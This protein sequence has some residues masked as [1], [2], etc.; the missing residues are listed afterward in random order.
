MNSPPFYRVIDPQNYTSYLPALAAKLPA[1]Q[2]NWVSYKNEI[3]RDSRFAICHYKIDYADGL[4]S[5]HYDVAKSKVTS[6]E[7]KTKTDPL[8]LDDPHVRGVLM[9]FLTDISDPGLTKVEVKLIQ[10][11]VFPFIFNP[12]R[13]SQFRRLKHIQ[14]LAT[15]VVSASGIEGGHMQLFHSENDKLGPFHCIEELPLSPGA[16]Y[17]VY[18]PPHVVFH[19]MR[20]AFKL[21]DDAHRAALL[22]RFFV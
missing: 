2:E 1:L 10:T 18:E 17:I 16:G 6:H 22:L 8:L 3:H 11:D 12:H 13:D 19:G 7:K 15:V 4:P 9:Q 21:E 5:L 20:P 14:Y